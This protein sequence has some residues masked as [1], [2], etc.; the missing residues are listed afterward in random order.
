M[1]QLKALQVFPLTDKIK[2]SAKAP[3]NI[4]A[5]K[6]YYVLQVT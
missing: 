2:A 5:R 3:K 4:L 1:A 6:N